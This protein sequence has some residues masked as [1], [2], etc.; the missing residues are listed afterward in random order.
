MKLK[1][2]LVD[3][4]ILLFSYVIFL[5]LLLLLMRAFRVD[6]SFILA[7]FLLFVFFG[8]FFFFYSFLRKKQFYDRLIFQ[9]KNLDQKYLLVEMLQEPT[10]LE[11]KI[12]WETLYECNKSM[13]ENLQQFKMQLTDFKEYLEMWIHEVKIPLSSLTLMAHN[14]QDQIDFKTLE[15]IKR[16]ESYV[17]QILYYV[18]S[19]NAEK[20]YLINSVPLKKV[21]MPIALNHKDDFLENRIE[22]KMEHLDH[23]VFTDSKW[24]EFIL[25][26]I[27][28]N[29]IK[30][31]RDDVHSYIKIYSVEDADSIRLIIEDNGIGICASDLPKV[32]EKSFT[33]HNGRMRVKST[34]MGLYI[35]KKLCMKLGHQISIESKEQEYTK[36]VLTFSKNRYFEVVQ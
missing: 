6:F 26:Q 16:I 28:H 10:F 33:G 12:L 35:A 17:D 36:V 24:L 13:C 7:T 3:H 11:G 31:R 29:S 25:N 14:H 2:F 30:Y 34:G 27:V 32:F 22:L 1:R 5:G 4:W 8:V 21:L 18:R 15:Q 23:K 19:E 9:L 20:D